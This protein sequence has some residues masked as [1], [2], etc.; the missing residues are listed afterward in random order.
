MTLVR[1]TELSHTP[2]ISSGPRRLWLLLAVS[3]L[4]GP[5]LCHAQTKA[6][7][8]DDLARQLLSRL[9]ETDQKSILVMDLQG[10]DGRWQAFGSWLADQVSVS[11]TAESTPI[12][13]VSRDRLAGALQEQNLSLTDEFD[14]NEAV[15][16][17]KSLGADAV[18]IGSYGALANELGVTLTAIHTSGSEP[19]FVVVNAKISLTPEVRAHLGVPPDSLRPKDGIFKGGVGGITLPACV[20]CSFP[21]MR[22]PDVDLSGL[23][24]DKPHGGDVVLELVIS[25]EGRVTHA[26]VSKPI[27]YGVDEQYVKAA[28]AFEFKPAVDPDNHPVAVH[29]SMSIH[30]AFK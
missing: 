10:P 9:I 17:G 22:V 2:P 3:A 23:L 4:I 24:R 7:A 30:M 19:S 26:A 28:Q 29:T 20:K 18:V 8:C 1:S 13:V 5:S 14:A 25:P 15:A 16:L 27:G 21:S 11:L 6:S 12:V